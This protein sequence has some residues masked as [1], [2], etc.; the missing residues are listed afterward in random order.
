MI[1]RGQRFYRLLAIRP[2]ESDDDLTGHPHG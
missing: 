1:L 2:N